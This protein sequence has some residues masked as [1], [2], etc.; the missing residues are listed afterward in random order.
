MKIDRNNR[1][2]EEVK[3]EV[4]DIIRS[5]LKDP[6]IGGMVSV[7]RADVTG[8]LRYARIYVSVMA[9]EKEKKATMKALKSAA[10]FVRREL[11]ARID[12]RYVPEIQFILDTSIEYSIHI[13]EV[14]KKVENDHKDV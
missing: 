1:I 11:G 9:D 12:L 6:R 2:N 8:D 5:D 3:R 13:N 7:I 14:L 10:G 4:S